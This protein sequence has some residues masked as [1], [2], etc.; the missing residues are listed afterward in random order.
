MLKI[1]KEDVEQVIP[2]KPVFDKIELIEPINCGLL[3]K[4]LK[5]AAH[6][7]CEFDSN[8]I[9]N[10][11]VCEDKDGELCITKLDFDLKKE[12]MLLHGNDIPEKIF[13]IIEKLMNLPFN[14]S[15]ITYLREIEKD[16]DYKDIISNQFYKEISSIIEEELRRI[17][18]LNINKFEWVY[19]IK[20]SINDKFDKYNMIKIRVDFKVYLLV[21]KDKYIFEKSSGEKIFEVKGDSMKIF[22]DG[23]L[24][25][26]AEFKPDEI[27]KRRD[28]MIKRFPCNKELIDILCLGVR[29]VE[30]VKKLRGEI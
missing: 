15:M 21:Y 12:Y 30:E 9:I 23:E 17:K 26:M 1:R 27:Y 28:M 3:T 14:D 6:K 29:A 8:V 13:E 7:T 4:T 5:F 18:V 10:L 25:A 19:K 11:A 20:D 22:F 2:D 24:Y 16:D